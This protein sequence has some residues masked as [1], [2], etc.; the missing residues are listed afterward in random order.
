[1]YKAFYSLSKDPFSKEFLA[2]DA[3]SYDN[4]REAISRLGYLK[5]ARGIGLITGDSGIGKTT[6]LRSF[7]HSLEPNL[8]RVMYTPMASGTVMDFYREL[9]LCLGEE[10]RYRKVDL[11]HQIQDACIELYF[12]RGITPVFI[13]DEMQAAKPSFLN[14]LS[15]LFNFNMDAKLPFILI[16]SGLPHLGTKLSLNL[17]RSLDS[18][19]V[20]R[21]EMEPMNHDEVNNFVVSR[22]EYAGVTRMIFTENA[23]AAISSVSRG[24]P[25]LICNICTHALIQGAVSNSQVIDEEI[26]KT[27]AI[28]AGL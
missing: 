2:S 22:L 24:I 5:K 7:A 6:V 13:L 21:F 9:A 23:L 25:R 27:A 16:L 12:K 19:I 15:L 17:N 10:P 11:F 26:I 18:R 28:E 4:F 14:D 1:V 8:Y 20:M 3:F